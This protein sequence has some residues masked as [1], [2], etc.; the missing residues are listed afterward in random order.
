MWLVAIVLD[1]AGLQDIFVKKIY[2]LPKYVHFQT[3][4]GL[5]NWKEED[6]TGLRDYHI[7]LLFF[8]DPGCGKKW[9]AV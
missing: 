8:R 7:G 2:Y 9:V 4:Q 1:D 3:L 5:F 6:K